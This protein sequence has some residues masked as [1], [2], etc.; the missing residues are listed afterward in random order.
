MTSAPAATSR[1][2]MPITAPVMKPSRLPIL[3]MIMAAGRAASATPML[4]P[5]TGAVASDLSV[6]RR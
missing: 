1:P 2:A 5:V 4:K 3:R 6:S